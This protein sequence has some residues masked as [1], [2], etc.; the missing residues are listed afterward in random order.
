LPPAINTLRRLRREARDE[1]N[2]LVQFLDQSDEYV[3][4]ELEEDDEREPEEAEPSLGSLDRAIDQNRWAFGSHDDTEH[5]HDGR[6]LDENREQDGLRE[7]I[8]RQDWQ[9]A[10]AVRST[11]EW[12]ERLPV[13]T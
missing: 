10:R 12:P 3:M 6:E 2:R 5:E 9:P 7:Q 13:S 1:I 11:S 8:G 4:T